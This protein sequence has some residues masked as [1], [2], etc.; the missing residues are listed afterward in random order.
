MISS[1][2]NKKLLNAKAII[3]LAIS[4]GVLSSCRKDKVS[5][6]DLESEQCD[7]LPISENSEPSFGYTEIQ[8]STYYLWP[9]YSPFNDY[10]ILYIDASYP[11]NMR[12]L[13]KFNLITNQKE[14]IYQGAII[15]KASW[16]KN[17]WILLTLNDHQIWKIKSNGDSLTPLTNNGNW[18]YPEINKNRDQFICYKGNAEPLFSAI[19]NLNGSIIDT[20]TCYSAQGSWDHST[21]YANI[22][23]D[24]ISIIN[25]FS[26][27]VSKVIYASSSELSY[28][29]FFWISDSEGIYTNKNGVFRINLNSLQ[30]SKLKC[31]CDSKIYQSGSINLSKTKMLFN[32]ISYSKIDNNT[33][34]IDGQLVLMN[35]DGT[36]EE[37]VLPH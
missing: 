13:F 20:F 4:V 14:L 23:N 30:S 10:E 27:Y 16:A 18:F 36:I 28:L 8:D 24:K 26:N 33:L 25:P 3:I 5:M 7:C 1:T 32:K 19:Y 12:K 35:M 6:N 34:A 17:N 2:I 31:S 9:E 21:Y 11:I 37:V 22:S 15:G 29:D